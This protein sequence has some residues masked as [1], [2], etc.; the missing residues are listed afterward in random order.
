MRQLTM[1]KI[2]MRFARRGAVRS[3][4]SSALQPDFRILWK[5]SI[6]HRIEYHSSFS[7]ASRRERTDMS[8]TSFQLILFRFRDV[9]ASSAWITVNVSA[10]YRFH[11]PIGGRIWI[12]R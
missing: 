9:P 6:F 2:E 10:G 5:T 3:L 7:M 11:F 1:Q 8:V 12:L 4:E